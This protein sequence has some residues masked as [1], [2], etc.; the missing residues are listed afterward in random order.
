MGGVYGSG[1]NVATASYG[2]AVVH[3]EKLP[4]RWM[5]ASIAVLVA[6]VL[7][8][9]GIL[10]PEDSTVWL[11]IVGASTLLAVV[12]NAVPLS[13][14]IYHRVRLENGQLTVGRETIAVESLTV[15]SLREA[16]EQPTDA[17][18]VAALGSRSP[19]ELAE[20]RRASRAAVPPRLMGG[21]WSVPMGMDEIV[22]ETVQGESL[23]IATHDRDALLDALT[24][25]RQI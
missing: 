20:L 8:Q 2:R 12:F 16:R 24:R 11:V 10:L 22:V 4:K 21:G 15:D 5:I 1:D 18:F 17:E 13:K 14:R 6:F 3:Q 7:Y 9:G 19:Q 25:A 23:L